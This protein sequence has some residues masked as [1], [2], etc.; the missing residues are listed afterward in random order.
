L[1]GTPVVREVAE[2]AQAA[3]AAPQP[4]RAFDLLLDGPATRFSADYPTGVPPLRKALDAFRHVDG[5]TAGDVRWLWL[6]C[7]LALD[8]WDEELWQVLATRGVRIA[9][10][11][12]A[13]M[14]LPG[15]A[16]FLA[17]FNVHGGTFD[18]AVVLIDEV[19][20]ITQAT[21]IP[22]LKYGA[23][24]LA[25]WRGD[26]EE[27]QAVADKEMPSVMARGEGLSLALLLSTTA[28]LHNGHARYGDAL[29]AAEQACEHEDVIAYG[30]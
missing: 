5:L 14:L 3:P 18:D 1:G 30:L 22:S 6:A 21:G 7:R 24:T 28:L 20:A 27:L 17:A 25:A 16:N 19:D 8:L 11:T 12:G 10:E 15:M 13:L 29:A 23:G 26:S 2:S 9:R 4:P